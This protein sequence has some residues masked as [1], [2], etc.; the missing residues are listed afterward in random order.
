MN[1]PGGA[2]CTFVRRRSSEPA[3]KANAGEPIVSLAL[4]GAR[5]CEDR[6]KAN[7]TSGELPKM[8]RVLTDLTLVVH[9]LFI[10]FVLA[11][12]FIARRRRWLTVVHLSAVLWA[13]Y[14]EIAAGVVCPLTALENYFAQRA[15]L[16]TYTGDFVARYL[17][18]I[19]YQEKVPPALQYV[20]VAIVVAVTVAA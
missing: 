3:E 1:P 8:F 9:A 16:A 7:K 10:L 19:I 4:A 5:G 20:L 2:S 18:P 12:G 14:A 13:V 15:G 17:V 6:L 11:G